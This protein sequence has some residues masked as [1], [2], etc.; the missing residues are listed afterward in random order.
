MLP[1]LDQTTM[2]VLSELYPDYDQVHEQVFV[3]IKDLPVE[4]N[5]RDLRQSHL[6]ALIK[7]RGVV[8]KRTT[9]FPELVKA[10]Y[11]CNNCQYMEGPVY[12]DRDQDRSILGPCNVC[13]SKAG[14]HV[15]E[16]Q[17]VYR[18]YQKWTI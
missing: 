12:L 15:E 6:N 8:T 13:R 5:L 11:K 3:R 10:F 14:F 9:V 4:D 7:I 18:N 17:S 16:F 2:Q 1:I